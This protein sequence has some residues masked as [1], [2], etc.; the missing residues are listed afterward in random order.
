MTKCRQYEDLGEI[1]LS[2]EVATH[3]ETA[4]AHAEQDLDEVRVNFRWGTSQLHLVKKA[5]DLAGV[6][7]QTYIKQ[8][9]YRQ[10]V[11]DLKDA[12]ALGLKTK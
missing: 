9:I 11:A 4:I 7:Y 2:P 1:E 8:V 6:P 10:A 12:T 3:A 5:A